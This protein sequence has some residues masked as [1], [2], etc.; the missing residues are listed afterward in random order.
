M[1]WTQV[2]WSTCQSELQAQVFGVIWKQILFVSGFLNK[3][4][5]KGTRTDEIMQKSYICNI[6]TSH[7]A[8]ANH[9]KTTSHKDNVF[10]LVG[11]VMQNVLSHF[12]PA[13]ELA[14]I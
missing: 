8:P 1:K 5:E 6:Q 4:Q 2:L 11:H 9:R 3:M 7:Q 13:G 10:T 14:L 12:V